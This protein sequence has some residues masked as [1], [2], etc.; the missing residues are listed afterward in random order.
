MDPGKGLCC[1]ALSQ[2]LHIL[3]HHFPSEGNGA[4]T[5]RHPEKAPVTRILHLAPRRTPLTT[6]FPVF[7]S[8]EGQKE[9]RTK[10]DCEYQLDATDW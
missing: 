9:A 5:A 8:S 6:K 1:P 7:Q 10:Q 3:P 4:L 2:T